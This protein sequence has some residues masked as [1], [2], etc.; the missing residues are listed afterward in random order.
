[1]KSLVTRHADILAVLRIYGEPTLSKVADKINL[2]RS[3]VTALVSKLEK[4]KYV[5]QRMNETDRRSSILFLTKKGKGLV[6]EFESIGNAY[7]GKRPR[8]S[9]KRNGSVFEE[10]LKKVHGKAL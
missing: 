10:C 2:D 4:F 3:T 5:Q 8:A 9:R 7:Y 1:M 6:P